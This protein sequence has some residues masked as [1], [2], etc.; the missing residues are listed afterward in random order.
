MEKLRA[1]PEDYEDL[2]I[3]FGSQPQT[4]WASALDFARQGKFESICT[5]GGLTVSGIACFKVDNPWAAMATVAVVLCFCAFMV[6][7]GKQK[8]DSDEPRNESAS[9]DQARGN[10]REDGRELVPGSPQIRFNP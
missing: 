8:N 1:S 7:Y 5:L 4:L 10:E 2:S 9:P 3:A 6:I